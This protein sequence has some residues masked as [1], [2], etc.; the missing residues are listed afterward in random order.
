M[1]VGKYSPTVANSY[2][3]DQSWWEKNGG[4]YDNGTDPK[5]PND[6]EGYDSYG[7]GGN[8][9]GP[10]RAGYTESQY[11][12]TSEEFGDDLVY[13]LYD[14]VGQDWASTLLGTRY[15]PTYPIKPDEPRRYPSHLDFKDGVDFEAVKAWREATGM[16]LQESKRELTRQAIYEAVA[17]A[18]S[19]EEA[20]PALLTLIGMMVTR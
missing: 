19:F 10:D 3:Q 17:K 7:Y 13:T 11:A 16:G 8:G 6:N 20:K 4:G 5:S 2:R 9:A 12:R 18:E 14:T 1:G 15:I